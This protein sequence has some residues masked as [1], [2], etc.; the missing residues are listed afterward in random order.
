LRVRRQSTHDLTEAR[1]AVKS[2]RVCLRL[3][4]PLVSQIQR[5][6]AAEDETA[7]VVMRRILRAGLRGL[8]YV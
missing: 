1:D 7:S 3:S 2:A 4:D 5:V 6:A 8:G